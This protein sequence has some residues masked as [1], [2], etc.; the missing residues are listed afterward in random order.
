FIKWFTSPEVQAKWVEISQ[1]FP[2]RAGAADFLGDYVSANPQFGTA[3]ELLQ[4]GKFEPQL[5]SYQSVRDAAEEALTQI[6]Q[7]ADVESTLNDLTE[8]ANEL[9]AEL[10]E[11]QG[12]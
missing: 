5:I 8:L 12:G 3:L 6:L 10:L 11:E 4:Y 7:G 2:T 1:Y 9:Q